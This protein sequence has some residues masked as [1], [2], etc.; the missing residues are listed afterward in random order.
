MKLAYTYVKKN[1]FWEI[2]KLV[3]YPFLSSVTKQVLLIALFA[4]LTIFFLSPCD[5]VPQIACADKKIIF[6]IEY[7]IEWIQRRLTVFIV[8]TNNWI[9]VG[10]ILL[11]T[12]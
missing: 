3:I 1:F 6:I 7:G 10:T 4:I 8:F 12:C 5:D 11:I 2:Y 9:D